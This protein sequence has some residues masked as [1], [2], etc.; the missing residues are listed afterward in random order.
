MSK[1]TTIIKK[2][3]LATL[4]ADAISELERAARLHPEWPSELNYHDEEEQESN[5]AI[6]RAI[7]D[8]DRAT[9]TTIF[10]EEWY[11]FL[12]AARKPGNIV[13]A[14]TELVQ[15][16]AMLLRISCHLGDYV[17]KAETGKMCPVDEEKCDL[18]AGV[19]GKP[20]PD[21]GTEVKS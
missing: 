20:C 21:A 2:P 12:L 4:C 7:N 3:E 17:P 11:E 18:C 15:A 16:M 8:H 5:L 10:A 6:A 13:A 14:R 1:L 9:G 19:L